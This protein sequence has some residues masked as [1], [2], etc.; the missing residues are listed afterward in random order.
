MR[1]LLRSLRPADTLEQGGRDVYRNLDT[2]HQQFWR[3]F[4]VLLRSREGEEVGNESPSFA[5][6]SI[7]HA[8]ST[9]R[10][11]ARPPSPLL[12][13]LQPSPTPATP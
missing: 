1:L 12:N 9:A 2:H 7:P 11:P 10:P 3:S 5:S 4:T 8:R 13:L 6:I